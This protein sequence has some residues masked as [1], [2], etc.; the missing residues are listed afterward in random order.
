[1]K[2]PST[3]IIFDT[4]RLRATK[5]D[6]VSY[7]EFQFSSEFETFNA[8]IQDTG[9]TDYVN[10]AIPDLVI[11]ELLQQKIEQF[12][13]DMTSISQIGERLKEL[14]NVD[15][16]AIKLPDQDF[17]AREH[18]RPKVE[19]YLKRNNF[20]ILTISVNSS[21]RVLSELRGRAIERRPPFRG[22]K[23]SK[24]AGFKDALIWQSILE[25]DYQKYDYVHFCTS[26]LDF[27]AELKFEF[28]K[29]IGKTIDITKSTTL[30]QANLEKRYF[31]LISN[32][33][34]IDYVSKDFYQDHL[35]NQL[36]RL[37]DIEIDG[38]L[39]KIKD[40][41]IV[42]LLE[43]IVPPLEEDSADAYTKIITALEGK[44]NQGD[45]WKPIRILA[46]TYFDDADGL[47]YTEFEAE[48][49]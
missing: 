30:I 26:D 10:I 22:S 20:V 33:K 5:A 46:V 34:W 45:I 25:N 39:Q 23:N 9:L 32:K 42:K 3:L 43:K 14:P 16:N 12:N 28:E 1:M 36:S 24:D 7:G 44:A 49:D 38:N 15:L 48:S 37:E 11:E 2:S 31:D 13:D 18:L 8:F 6:G 21:D 19:A 4:N 47:Q 35:M 27:V 17:K 40:V 41:K 29:Y